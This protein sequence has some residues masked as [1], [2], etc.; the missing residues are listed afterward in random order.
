MT[1]SPEAP[2]PLGRVVMAVKD[3]VGRLGEIWVDA[4]VIEIKRRRGATQFLT[5]RDR[6]AEISA[7][8]TVSALVLDSAGPLPEGSQVVARLR[9]RIW[10]RNAS[11][12][13]ECL[14][15]RAAGEGRLLAQLEALKAKLRAEGLFEPHRKKRLP[16]IPRRIGLITSAGSDAERDVMTNTSR[17]WPA[18]FTLRSVPVQGVHAAES[19]LT[20][21]R[22]LDADPA[23]DV[24]ILARGGGALQDLLPFSDEGMVRAV[25]ACSTPVITAIGHEQDYPL[26]D[27]VA[28]ARASTPTDAA[29]L[30]APDFLAENE[31]VRQARTRLG[32]AVTNR[33]DAAQQALND[34]RSRPVMRDPMS[35]FAAHHD[36]LHLLRHQL[37]DSIGRRLEAEDRVL[38]NALT[39][40]RATSPKA[41]LERGYAVLVDEDQASVS[42]VVDVEA[43]QRIRAWLADGQLELDV[44][45]VHPAQGEQ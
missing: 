6:M 34:V 2:Q 40:I 35:A 38:Q 14:E 7:T 33:L 41:T 21:L 32:Q 13:F 19:I 24:I 15:L 28:D 1:S 10:D 26:V 17:R 16:F 45:G 23:V 27:F 3:W 30:V 42:S 44:H 37:R 22:D 18:V 31:L 25:A 43:G 39:T 5:F 20:A 8:V 9:P 4:Q 11:L 12:S 29:S 36:R